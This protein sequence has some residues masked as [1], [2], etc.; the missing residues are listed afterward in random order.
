MIKSYA[1]SP[2]FVL[3]LQ[4]SIVGTGLISPM[5]FMKQRGLFIK[6]SGTIPG[7][8]VEFRP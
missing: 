5:D 3:I 2:F 7:V 8:A 4:E 6:H 1:I